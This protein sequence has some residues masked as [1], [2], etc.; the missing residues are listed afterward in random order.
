MTKIPMTKKIRLT[1]TSIGY[2]GIAEARSR[3]GLRLVLG[4]YA[5]PGP[6]RE[7]CKALFHVKEIPY[8]PVA[9]ASPGHADG[10]FGMDGA[11]RELLEWTGQ[12]SAPVAIWNDEKPC[13]TWIEQ[14]QLAE[15]LAPTPSLVPE[16]VED[17]ALMF[18]LSHELCGREGFGWTKRIA[19]IHANLT[20][21]G[22][23]H[24]ARR[25][26]VH[27]A[28]KYGYTPAA[29]EAAPARLARIVR[30]FARRIERQHDAGRRYFI[31]DRLSA[32]D[33]YWSTFVAMLAPMDESRCP[34]ASAFR[35]AYTNPDLEVQ[36]ALTPL[37]IAHR[38]FVYRE[39]LE[40]PVRF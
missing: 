9:T 4:A 15:R 35:A 32:L 34:M 39:H 21:L 14:L 11:D 18:G 40:L 19:M 3:P 7:A 20:T 22:I 24:P 28:G 5:V 25:F 16:G 38:D 36:R 13:T 30:A 26:W 29:G 33:I 37:L 2:L 8:L 27:M 31:G 10:D 17:R 6:W 12:S 23:D 1:D